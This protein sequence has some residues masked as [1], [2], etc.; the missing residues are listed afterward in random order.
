HDW[1]VIIVDDAS[2]DDSVEIIEDIIKDDKRFLL[3]KN[4]INKG[5]GFTKRKCVEKA[6]GKFCGFLD[7]DD[8]L[9][10]HALEEMVNAFNNNPVEVLIH[11]NLF[12]CSETL[13]RKGLHPSAGAVKDIGDFYFNYAPPYNNAGPVIAFTSFKKS[14]YLAT[15]GIDPYML[16]AVDQDLYLKLWEVGPFFY[17]DK[18][19]YLYRIHEGGIS[20]ANKEGRA[21][22]WHWYA[23]MQAAKRRNI[24][25]EDMFVQVFISKGKYDR[26]LS[27]LNNSEFHKLSKIFAPVKG[28]LKSLGFFTDPKQKK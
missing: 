10:P 26:L 28:A 27:S 4:E 2:T 23:V 20:H 6:G 19:L 17:L 18:P 8:A 5:C 15:E 25:I 9:L 1:E 7:P 3:F 24:N 16:R 12:I 11:S 22:Y 21:F 14:A 13:D